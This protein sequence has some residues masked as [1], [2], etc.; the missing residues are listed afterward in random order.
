MGDAWDVVVIGAGTAGAA[1]G[2]HCA[3]RGLR[4]LIVDRGTLEDAGAAWVNGVPRAAFAEADIPPPTAPELRGEGEPM[5]LVA[6]WDGPQ[7]SVT[8]DVLELDM[9]LLGRRLRALAGDAGAELR[10]LTIQGWEDRDAGLLATTDGVIEARWVV[11]ASGLRSTGLMSRPE[12]PPEH[13]CVAAQAVHRCADRSAAEAWFVAR[14]SSFGPAL[15][16][17][18]IAG[19]FSIVNVR[20]EGDEVSVLTGSLAGSDQPAGS[21]LLRDFVDSQP[22]VGERLFGGA[23]AIPLRRPF[24]RLADDRVALL[25]DA[26]SQVFSAHGSGIAAGLIAARMLAEALASGG[27]PRAYEV[28]WMRTHG[29]R[30]AAYDLFRRF[31]QTLSIDDVATLMRSGLMDP[32]TSRAALEQRLVPVTFGLVAAKVWAALKAPA[33]AARMLGLIASMHRVRT[34]YD[35]YPE[36]RAQLPDWARRVATIFG[37]SPDA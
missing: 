8:S 33:Q 12:V 31:S 16:F 35:H 10:S 24:D 17:T 30:F 32:M 4:T 14:G 21:V 20:C 3:R 36:D 18:G 34:L 7:M 29:G 27:G 28:T 25:G 15:V 22:W 9:R 5:Q 26:A 1:A 37:E 19:G 6:G 2:L 11:D 13:L 23:R